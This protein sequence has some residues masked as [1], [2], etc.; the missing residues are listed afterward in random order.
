MLALYL[1]ES[2]EPSKV[3]V[4]AAPD[5]I[6]VALSAASASYGLRRREAQGQD[7]SK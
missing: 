6:R 4:Q 2:Y 1:A 5:R 7:C 3:P